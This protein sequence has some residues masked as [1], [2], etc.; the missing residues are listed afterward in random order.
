MQ[1]LP[2]LGEGAL[3]CDAVG[4]SAAGIT[5]HNPANLSRIAVADLA[6]RLA[7]AQLV[8]EG[9]LDL[10][11]GAG[12]VP[13][14]GHAYDALAAHGLQGALELLLHFLCARELR[15]LRHHGGK[16]LHRGCIVYL[17]VLVVLHHG[18][19]HSAAE[20]ANVEEQAEKDNYCHGLGL[21]LPTPSHDTTKL[22]GCPHIAQAQLEHL[23]V[24]GV[25][26]GAPEKDGKECPSKPE[27]M[28]PEVQ[29]D[30]GSTRRSLPGEVGRQRVQGPC[31]LLSFLPGRLGLSQL[32]QGAEHQAALNTSTVRHGTAPQ[33]DIPDH[34][35]KHEDNENDANNL[36]DNAHGVS[37]LPLVRVIA[38]DTLLAVI[39]TRGTLCAT[40]DSAGPTITPP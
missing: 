29:S 20:R 37:A 7:G 40:K 19:Q 36:R 4:R 2:R 8:V 6:H 1:G 21:Q 38:G 18:K 10:A 12:Q 14:D 32:R 34:H 26:H 28:E 9:V 3:V 11:H 30:R 31:L 22:H 35:I 39:L 24:R 27:E 25:R 17:D 33:V 15:E 16:V 13:S 23:A 5:R